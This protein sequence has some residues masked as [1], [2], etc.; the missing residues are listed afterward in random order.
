MDFSGPRG[1][2]TAPSASWARD[3]DPWAWGSVK[4]PKRATDRAERGTW[5][6]SEPRQALWRPQRPGKATSKK[7][8]EIARKTAKKTRGKSTKRSI[9]IS[10][11]NH[12]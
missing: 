2:L 7:E 10:S 11:D 1:A 9:I 8:V 6:S 4:G 3:A 12:C 5:S